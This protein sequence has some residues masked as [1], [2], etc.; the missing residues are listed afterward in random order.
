MVLN[1]Q[2]AL[3]ATSDSSPY[4]MREQGNG[5]SLLSPTKSQEVQILIPTFPQHACLRW[6]EGDKRN[7]KDSLVNV[8][9]VSTLAASCQNAVDSA[10]IK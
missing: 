9:A 6:W 10:A 3:G 4:E 8:D 1:C 5:Q 2:S 7:E